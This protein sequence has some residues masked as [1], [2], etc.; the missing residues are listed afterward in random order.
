M[1]N[2]QPTRN[3]CVFTLKS[4]VDETT[5]NNSIKFKE[6]YDYKLKQIKKDINQYGFN[7]ENDNNDDFKEL[8]IL[9]NETKKDDIKRFAN[10]SYHI[11]KS[12]LNN[13]ITTQ[14]LKKLLVNIYNKNQNIIKNS[15]FRKVLVYY[16]YIINR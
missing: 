9:I 12:R 5:F 15:F 2:I 6:N 11:L 1:V 4:N 10:L 8:S 16:D 14:S 7:F 3:V 13:K